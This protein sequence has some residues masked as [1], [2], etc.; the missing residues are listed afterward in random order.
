[1][2]PSAGP[3]TT[4]TPPTSLWRHH[5]FRQL[6]AGD[7]VSVTGMQLVAFAMPLMA[8]QL[9]QADAFQMGILAADHR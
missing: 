6:W 9:L 5:D 4:T 2:P 3:G 8:V 7:T 1:M